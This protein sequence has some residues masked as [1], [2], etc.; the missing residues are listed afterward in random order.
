MKNFSGFN[1]PEKVVQMNM[2]RTLNFNVDLYESYS[3]LAS[4]Y[5]EVLQGEANGR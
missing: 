1:T 2:D 3:A 4:Q 5:S